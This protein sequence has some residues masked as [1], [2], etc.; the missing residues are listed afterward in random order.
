MAQ[1]FYNARVHIPNLDLTYDELNNVL[2]ETAKEIESRRKEDRRLC[3]SEEAGN[4]RQ[5]HC[6]RPWTECRSGI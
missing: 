6:Y 4:R 5:G 2:Q 3:S 1:S